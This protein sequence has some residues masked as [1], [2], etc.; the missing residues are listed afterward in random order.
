VSNR[1]A[2]DIG[3]GREYNAKDLVGDNLWRKVQGLG[4]RVSGFGYSI[5]F[6]D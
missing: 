1:P 3:H 5:N 6:G 2:G 4:L